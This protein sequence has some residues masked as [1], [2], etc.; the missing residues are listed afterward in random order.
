MRFMMCN[1]FKDYMI[2]SRNLLTVTAC[3]SLD[4]GRVVSLYDADN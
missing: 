1:A 3:S 2:I 4:G